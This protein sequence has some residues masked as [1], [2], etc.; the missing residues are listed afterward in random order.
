MM[1]L[2][3]LARRFRKDERGVTL[4]EYG[5]GIT[6]AVV[7]GIGALSALAGDVAVGMQAAGTKICN[8][9]TAPTTTG[10]YATGTC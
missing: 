7:L 2:K 3:N 9:V 4:V 5:I 1:N 8:D 6:L 10:G